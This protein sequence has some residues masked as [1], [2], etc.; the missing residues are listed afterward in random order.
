MF[1]KFKNYILQPFGYFCAIERVVGFSGLPEDVKVWLEWL[2]MIPDFIAY[3]AITIAI[4][5]TWQ[6]D[7]GVRQRA[8]ISNM[9]HTKFEPKGKILDHH[10]ESFSIS[11]DFIHTIIGLVLFLILGGVIYFDYKTT[12]EFEWINPT[13]D[14]TEQKQ[15]ILQCEIE[16]LDKFGG[17]FRT[18][19]EYE[20]KC[21]EIQGFEYVEV[22]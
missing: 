3:P 14:E 11:D 20:K 8:K 17:N 7:W 21:L 19:R 6:S 5:I 15:I 10:R 16:A 9:W 13:M 12:P 22:E 1:N 2:Q 4:I 18:R